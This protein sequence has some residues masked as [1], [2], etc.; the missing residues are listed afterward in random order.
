MW[1]IGRAF[2]EGEPLGLEPSND[3]VF[4]LSDS[5]YSF[6]IAFGKHR[7]EDVNFFVQE[8]ERPGILNAFY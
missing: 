1:A 5:S 8:K 7:N 4:L 6:I 2:Y 3:R